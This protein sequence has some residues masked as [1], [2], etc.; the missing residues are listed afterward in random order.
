M[1]LR[2]LERPEV[3]GMRVLAVA[4]NMTMVAI[5]TELKRAY[6]KR[7]IAT[8]VAPMVVLRLLALFDPQIKA[9]LPAVGKSHPMSNARA[10]EVLD[11]RFISPEGALR[12]SAD[13]LL[14]KGE[15]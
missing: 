10:R 9:I 2:A 3:S 13:W 12:A 7:R 14:E 4:G 6:P 11:M 8:R 1:H 5:A 15:V